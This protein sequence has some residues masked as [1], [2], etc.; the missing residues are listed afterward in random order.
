AIRVFTPAKPRLNAAARPRCRRARLQY[1]QSPLETAIDT[2]VET[3]GTPVL[4]R[5][6][7][8]LIEWQ[9]PPATVVRFVHKQFLK[10]LKHL[11]AIRPAVFFLQTRE[12]LFQ[13][14]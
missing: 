10:S 12:H 2:V 8:F 4:Q 5:S 7:S 11:P 3:D 1:E 14:G 13:H 6:Q 9:C